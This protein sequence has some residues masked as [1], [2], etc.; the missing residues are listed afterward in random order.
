M[1]IWYQHGSEH[2]ANLVMIGHFRDATEATKAKE[3]IDAISKQVAEDQRTGA[4]V[5]GSPSERF[6]KE[7]LDVLR[8]L[9]IGAIGPHE[10]EQ[11]AYDVAV[12]VEEDKVVVTTDE[13]DISAFLKVMFLRGA[14]IEVY[15]GLTASTSPY[16]GSQGH[17]RD[18]RLRRASA[19]L[20]RG[21]RELEANSSAVAERR[22]ICSLPAL[23][24]PGIQPLA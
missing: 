10:L 11:F 19:C 12:K 1:K 3:V 4:L 23:V 8:R 14:R 13:F 9:N 18:R 5:I 2:S 6:G 16:V 24:R 15:A 21:A 7:M 17:G 20:R 22:P